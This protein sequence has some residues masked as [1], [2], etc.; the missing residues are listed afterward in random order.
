[1]SRRTQ[2]QQVLDLLK[3]RGG[4]GVGAHELTY[5]HGITRAAAIIWQLRHD[6]GLNIRTIDKPGQQAVYILDG[7]AHTAML[8][9]TV[10]SNVPSRQK[11]PPEVPG[12]QAM[13]EDVSWTELGARFSA[14]RHGTPQEETP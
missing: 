13:F 6:D 9:P 3:E 14:E 12:Q 11:P 7:P 2:K 1:M 5:Q 10:V 4:N 8:R